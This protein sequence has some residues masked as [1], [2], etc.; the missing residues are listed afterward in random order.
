MQKQN[1]RAVPDE[2]GEIESHNEDE[3]PQR[4]SE[5]TYTSEAKSQPLFKTIRTWVQSVLGMEDAQASLKEAISEIVDETD[6]E[7]LVLG[8]EAK[9]MLHNILEFFDLKISDIMIPRVNICA[10]EE[11][12]T[13]DEIKASIRDHE[14]SRVPVYRQSLDE[15]IGFIHA[16]DLI[17]YTG[18]DTD[19][20]LKDFVRNILVVPPSMRV[21]D[22]LVKMRQSR[23]HIAIVVDEFGGTD[24]LV[25]LEDIFEEIV[26][27]IQ[28]EHDESEE[29]QQIRKVSDGVF[30]ADARLEIEVLEKLL[31]REVE[32]EDERD[33]DTLG[34]LVFS[35]LGQ[36]PSKGEV[37]ES[38]GLKFE[39]IDADSRRIKKV[40]ITILKNP[41]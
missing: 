17:T 2:A 3:P 6:T 26:G 12:S 14:H 15:V 4:G 16:K 34:G 13:L 11:R 25:T 18:H 37:V 41:E 30:E 38:H 29:S 32:D 27:D 24:G 10:V 39:I 9:K 7:N 33:Y 5:T 23:V 1:L 19:F 35:S 36:V 22:L 28:D 40:R 21:M 8:H 20:R 31:G